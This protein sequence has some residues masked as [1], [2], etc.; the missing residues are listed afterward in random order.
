MTVETGP[1]V[2]PNER[3][4]SS[5]LTRF[6][7]LAFAITWVLVAPIAASHQGWISANIGESWHW[8]GALGPLGAAWWVGRT[9]AGSLS[10]GAALPAG[11]FRPGSTLLRSARLSSWSPPRCG[12]EL[13]TVYGRTWAP[14]AAQPASGRVAG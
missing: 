7:L 13:Q 14:W 8:L 5:G 4:T 12:Y 6:L 11:G 9:T 1:R 3:R 10:C 2:I